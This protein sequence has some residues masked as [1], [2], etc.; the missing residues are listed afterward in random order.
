MRDGGIDIIASYVFW[1]HHEETEG[2][3]DFSGNK[4][5][6]KFLKVCRKL[7]LPFVLRLG[8]WVH[9]EARNGGFPDWL[10]SKTCGA[11]RKDAEPYM[12]YVR[13][14]LEA[15]Y[16]EVKDCMDVIVG[17]QL[18]NELRGGADY[19]KKLKEMII[20]IG[21]KTTYWTFTGWGGSD[22][23]GS[24]PFG[25]VLCLYGGYPEAPWLGHVN[26]FDNCD[27][28][29]FFN[30]RDDSNIGIDLLKTSPKDEH[31]ASA[32]NY[33]TPY[34]TCELGGGVQPTYHRRPF[35]STQDVLSTAICK[36]GSGSNG[37]GYY[38]FHGGRNPIGKTTM[39]ESRQTNY[40]NDLPMI[41]YDFQAPIGE[42]GQI[43][44]RYFELSKIHKFLNLEGEKLAVM[45]AFF[46]D[47][48]P[49]NPSDFEVLRCAVRSNG[50]VGYLF[51]SN[52]YHNKKTKTL[53]DT[54][55]I[56]LPID[57]TTIEIPVEIAPMSAG[58][59]PFNYTIGSEE[60]L[61]V[62]ALPQYENEDEIYFS[63]FSGIK[64]MICMKGDAPIPLTDKMTVGGKTIFFTPEESIPEMHT[65][66]I[67]LASHTVSNDDSFFRHI[68]NYDKT[69]PT[70]APT[71]EYTF[72]LPKDA[73]YLC[74]QAFGNIGA[75]YCDGALISDFYLYNDKW[76]VKVSNL[77]KESE[78][79]LKILP[80]TEEDK[81]K[82]YFEFDMPTGTHT[83]TVTAIFDDVIYV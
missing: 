45:P 72:K 48:T 73:K 18:E 55:K 26:S 61:W 47:V 20:D 5:I 44:E 35:I 32:A 80:L 11:I 69:L 53:S 50:R 24:C 78:L 67:A 62:S 23:P 28:F 17:I 63:K 21:F 49:A 83:P 51:V 36:L 29:I 34:L 43:R 68:V 57:N 56:N 64:P 6:N 81:E 40:P 42:A 66:N 10:K 9:G 8:P 79:I 2:Q 16:N 31:S 39:Q 25:E 82:I 22:L 71:D 52:H 75:L 3:F 77:P 33:K 15:L 54:V 14:Y 12:S 1:I 4:N 30:R 70:F 65:E 13:R 37:L 38:V 58:I 60:V 74:I 76:I 27:S 46:P 19:V 7:R 41:S 59:I